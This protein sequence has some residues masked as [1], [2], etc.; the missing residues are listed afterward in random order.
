MA[1]KEYQQQQK[2]YQD[3]MKA[4][5]AA[6]NARV[7]GDIPDELPGDFFTNVKYRK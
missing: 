3:R 1:S 4:S 6:S 5:I 2:E 7:R